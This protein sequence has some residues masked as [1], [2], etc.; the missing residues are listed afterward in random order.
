MNGHCRRAIQTL[1]ALGFTRE[2]RANGKAV[3]TH[4]NAPEV[5][6]K[7]WAG[8]A[9]L[10]SR[11]VIDK[12]RQV[13]GLS[14]SGHQTTATLRETARIKR[15]DAKRKEAAKAGREAAE[16]ARYEAAAQQRKAEREAARDLERAA[17][18]RREIARL[19]MPGG[20]R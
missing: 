13:A 16:R 4:A 14:T 20:A 9:E 11:A 1:D 5:E 8:M 10:A 2:D 15:Q 7:T 3:W 18:R 17:A 12:A 6:L 19:M